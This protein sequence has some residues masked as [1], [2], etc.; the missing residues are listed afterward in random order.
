MLLVYY[1]KGKGKTTA[2]Y[3]TAFR[4]LGRGWRV[5]VAS[6]MKSGDSGEV[7]LL[8]ELKLPV[9]VYVLG[10]VEFVK[11]GDYEAEV[12]SLNMVK[13]YAFLKHVL[14]RLMKSFRPKLVVL[15]ELGLAVHLALVDEATATRVLK[16]F[17]GNKELHAIVTGRY[18]PS[19]VKNMADL[20]SEVREV[21]HYFRKGFVNVEGLDR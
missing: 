17:A 6:F 2:A 16:K 15:D 5:V 18:V 3:G 1:G 8:R 19:T 9:R 7:K 10:T 11:P 13:A 14:P 4:A 21:R 12:A 20:V